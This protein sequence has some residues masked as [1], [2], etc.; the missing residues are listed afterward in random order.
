MKVIAI[1]NQKGGVGKT[2]TAVNLA[3]ALAA[4]GKEILLIDV[5]SQANATSALGIAVAG[6]HSLYQV[7]IGNKRLDEVMFATGRRHLSIV[8]AH[9]DLSGVDPRRGAHR[10]YAARAGRLARGQSI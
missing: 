10:L 1:A 2:S 3:A 6:E 8:P 9:M 5:D 4:R 7:L